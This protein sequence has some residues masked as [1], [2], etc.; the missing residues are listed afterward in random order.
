MSGDFYFKV[1]NRI[2]LTHSTK[3]EGVS[4][5]KAKT[6]TLRYEEGERYTSDGIPKHKQGKNYFKNRKYIMTDYTGHQYT[7]KPSRFILLIEVNEQIVETWIDKYFKDNVGRLTEK[8][9]MAIRDSMP[10]TVLVE[11]F[12]S[13]DGKQYYVVD[14]SCLDQWRT[15]AG[16]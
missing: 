16:L 3:K 6:I 10:E 7:T 1:T 11:Q 5:I 12:E 2:K 13:R 9:R 14:E 4:L 15:T 8:R